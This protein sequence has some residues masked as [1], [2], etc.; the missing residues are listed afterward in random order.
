[1]FVAGVRVVEFGSNGYSV[2][3]AIRKLRVRL[4]AVLLPGNGQIPFSDLV[5]E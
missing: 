1:M 3:L 5:Y 2:G 4:L